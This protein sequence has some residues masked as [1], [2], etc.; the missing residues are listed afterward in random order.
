MR[1]YLL[2][3]EKEAKNAEEN[4]AKKTL[5]SIQS[6]VDEIDNLKKELMTKDREIERL[7]T[8]R[9]ILSNLF[10]KGIIDAEGNVLKL[11]FSKFIPYNPILFNLLAY[12]ISLFATF[13][14]HNY[15]SRDVLQRSYCIG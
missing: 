4:M 7:E 1:K 14:Y 6:L 2:R 15:S 9:Y 5:D 11:T 3:K 10:D 8:E 12:E 13:I